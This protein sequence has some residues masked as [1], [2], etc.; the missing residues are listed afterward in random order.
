MGIK[1][2]EPKGSQLEQRLKKRWPDLE[3]YDES[4]EGG[5]DY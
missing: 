1:N 5:P 3:Y 4:S 2:G